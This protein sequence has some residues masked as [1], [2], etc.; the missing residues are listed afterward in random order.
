MEPTNLYTLFQD[1]TQLHAALHNPYTT[2]TTTLQ[3]FHQTSHNFN[4]FSQLYTTLHNF[5]R[6]YTI[7]PNNPNICEY[8]QEYTQLYATLRNSASLHENIRHYTKLYTNLQ[9]VT[10]V[11]KLHNTLQHF[12]NTCCV[13]Y[14]NITSQ[15]TL[16]NYS[17]IV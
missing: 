8:R 5:T 13:F 3:H 14:K 12:Y 2:F 1:S 11:T 4:T 6:L 7:L 16:Q 17:I 9:K 10:N 15:T